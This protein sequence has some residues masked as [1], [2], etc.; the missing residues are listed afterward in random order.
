MSRFAGDLL[1]VLSICAVLIIHGTG[2]F[3]SGFALNH[4]F[5]SQ[6]FFAVMLNQLARFAVPVF[7]IL[8]GYGLTKKYLKI[9]LR[10]FFLRRATRIGIPFIAWTLIFAVTNQ[11]MWNA[12]LIYSPGLWGASLLDIASRLPGYLFIQGVDYHFYFFIIILQCYLVFPLLFKL[13]Q[14]WV[15]FAILAWHLL[16]TSP[17]H[18]LLYKVGVTLPALP[19]SSIVFW[20]FYFYSGMKFARNEPER[21]SGSW[22]LVAFAVVFGEFIFWSYSNP[23]GSTGDYDHFNR[24][25]VTLYSML[26]LVS[27]PFAQLIEQKLG[28]NKWIPAL[29]G[30]SF[31]VFILH[32][33]ILRLL[34]FTWISR[35]VFALLLLLLVISF[36]LCLVL[37]RVVPW[38][39]LRI[40]LGLPERRV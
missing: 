35:S 13:N 25:S 20:V 1:R 28:T 32:T 15:W 18:I 9:D 3:E 12:A 5:A 17:S 36:G 6:E 23:T 4:E 31:T 37:D 27:R 7:L 40:V 8:S 29:A 22:V 2:R 19:S 11:I 24:W 38:N 26:F 16:W 14:T 10:E 39:S 33:N 21:R 30:V 34:E